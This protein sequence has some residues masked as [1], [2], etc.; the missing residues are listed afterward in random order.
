MKTY[1]LTKHNNIKTYWS[2]EGIS[3]RTGRFTPGVLAP[4]THWIGSW[5][6]PRTGLDAMVKRKNPITAPAG[7]WILVVLPV[8]QSLYWLSYPGSLKYMSE[9]VVIKLLQ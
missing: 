2:S 4:G 5:V 8:A 3:P 1:L 7:K 6:G 9:I